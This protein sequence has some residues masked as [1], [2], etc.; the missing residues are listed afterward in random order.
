[1][2][3]LTTINHALG[4]ISWP[5]SDGVKAVWEEVDLFAA[6]RTSNDTRIRQEASVSWRAP[7]VHSPIARLISRASANL[8]FG[9]PAAITPAEEGDAD[10]LDFLVTENGLDAELQ[11]AALLASSEGEIWGRIVVD[12]D[13]ADV[14]ILDFVS[15]ARVIPHFRGRF[16]VGATFVTEWPTTATERVRLLETY[17]P[18]YV[19]AKLYRGTTIVLGQEMDLDA[20]EPTKG[21]QPLVQTGIPKALVA[22][23]PNSFDAD[24]T[25]GYSDYRGLED[26]FLALNEGWTIGASNL[27]LAGKKRALVDAEYLDANGRLPAMD[28]VFIRRDKS[29]LAGEG[30]KPLQMIEYSFEAESI[31]RWLGELFD[32]TL[33]FAGLAP[34]SV[35]RAVDGGAI[36]GTALKLKMAHSL[37][38]ASG[39]GRHFDRGVG[40]LLGFAAQIDSRPVASGGFGRGWT[41]AESQPA[42]ARADGLPRD[43][44]EAAQIIVALTNAEAISLEEKVR[45]AHPEWTPEQVG[46]EVE[47]IEKEAGDSTAEGGS[48][49]ETIRPPL[50]LPGAGSAPILPADE[51]EA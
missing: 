45:M 24:V 16:C 2:G 18:G 30:G 34:Q 43:D 4:R 28:D 39:K 44:V 46:D 14:P 1:M 9:E 35:G 51:V 32:T 21:K 42:I 40:R 17:G 36:S 19:E 48:T 41:D 20:F 5:P 13:A 12:P 31:M 11:R 47:R 25:R 26:R 7:Y 27:R 22:F 38:E 49:I 10:P 23:I 50:T 37:V 15:R 29:A 8:L 3:I 33:L 6:F